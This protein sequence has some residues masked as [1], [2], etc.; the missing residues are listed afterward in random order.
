MT[1]ASNQDDDDDQHQWRKELDRIKHGES[2]GKTLLTVLP[3]SLADLFRDS[4]KSFPVAP[5][6]LVPPFLA[7]SASIFGK[8]GKVL[9]KGSHKEPLVFWFGTIAEPSAMKS[10]VAAS[11]LAPLQTLY[12]EVRAHYQ[13]DLNK[14]NAAIAQAQRRQK[15]IEAKRKD[16]SITDA[17][18]AELRELEARK[19][20]M[21]ELREFF[22]G[23]DISWEQIG[24]GSSGQSALSDALG[25]HNVQN[26]P[27]VVEFWHNQPIS[28]N[29]NPLPLFVGPLIA[30]MGTPI[31][32]SGSGQ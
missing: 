32:W 28:L 20:D 4:A 18:E 25:R 12:E 15:E 6:M 13:E 14:W 19:P 1:A 17:D 10:P 23:E 11:L 8:R 27:L 3:P 2:I 21:P 9:V 16:N 22:I 7:I 26:E 5:E 24:Q 31:P 29:L 30:Q